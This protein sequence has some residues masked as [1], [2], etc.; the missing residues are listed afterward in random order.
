MKLENLIRIPNFKHFKQSVSFKLDFV[1][2]MTIK[3]YVFTEHLFELSD[4]FLIPNI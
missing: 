3:Q 1:A 2:L 4:Y